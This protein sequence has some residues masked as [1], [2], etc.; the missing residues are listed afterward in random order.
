MNKLFRNY[1]LLLFAALSVT[2]VSCKDDE[3]P[4]DLEPTI[5]A[6][7]P[8]EGAPGTSV[9]ITGSNLDNA[10]SV[11]FGT[12]N[13]DIASNT[14]TSIVTTVPPNVS[15]GTTEISVT[16]AAGT[17]TANFN[18][19]DDTTE[20]ETATITGIDP[21]TGGTGTRVTITGTNLTGITGLRVGET[22]IAAEDFE[23][24]EAGENA[25]FTI[26]EDAAEGA[27]TGPITVTTAEGDEVAGPDDVTFTFDPELTPTV[28]AVD[29]ENMTAAVG[30][31]VTITGTNFEGAQVFFMNAEGEE[32]EAD[33]E[34]TSTTE[35]LIF[36]IPEGAVTGPI[37]IRATGGATQT[38]EFTVGEAGARITG[39]SPTT[40]GPGSRV[41]LTGTNLTG[42]TGLRAGETDIAAGDFE[43]D[44][45]GENVTFTIPNE[46]TEGFTGP[47]TVTTA[48]GEEVAGP[49]DV[50]FTF[51]ATGPGITS[52]DP[53][54]MT[55]AVGDV[56]TVTGRNLESAEVFFV[57]EAGEEVPATVD[58]TS[59][60]ET[61]VFTIP[62]GAVTG[63]II[64]R[65]PTD[66]E[67]QTGT[68]TIDGDAGQGQAINENGS[69]ENAE[70]GTIET[71][72]GAV[73][74]WSFG[75][76]DEGLATFAIVEDPVHEGNRA[77]AVTINELGG[78]AWDIQAINE[79]ITVEPGTTYNYSVWAR[80][81]EGTSATFTV[82]RPDF[83][84]FQGA[85]TT[86][87]MTGDWQEITMQFTTD[88]DDTEARTPIHFSIEG[89]VGQ[90]I[91]IDHL[92][93]TPAE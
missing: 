3:D 42:I 78:N 83:S 11:R 92:E 7:S 9:T 45:A 26:P 34:E 27:F 37:I 17:A 80:G 70:V 30:Q 43:V 90:T 32:V 23:V 18:V 20:P 86:V 57:N 15:P 2:V 28:T 33:L 67:T 74:G 24:D 89:N 77:L 19:L 25:T 54:N 72:E 49:E 61:L 35:T 1:L 93:I 71:N 41:T 51:S 63:P 59:T 87:E 79:G 14:G 47:F 46:A 16:T 10:T 38:E 52:V 36:T 66:E 22:D 6:V 73:E 29:P 21:V 31:T 85:S 48:E 84:E 56:V 5:T 91:Y 62:E 39:V 88:E 69:F 8:D 50:T 4:I 13:A 65:T 44:E 60:P 53:E 58:Q 40:G 55:G 75:G 68:F 82:G 76:I 81:P 64:I 12:V